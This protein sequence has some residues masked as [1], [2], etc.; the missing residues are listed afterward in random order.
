MLHYALQFVHE[1][2]THLF[3]RQ[4]SGN[5]YKY[6]EEVWRSY[7]ALRGIEDGVSQPVFPAKYGVV[8]RDEF[9]TSVAFQNVW[10]GSSGHDAPLIAY[11]ALL[12]CGGDWCE[13]IRRACLHGGDSDSTG[14]IACTWYG[15]LY[16]FRGVPK[17]HYAKLEYGARLRSLANQLYTM[18]G[19]VDDDELAV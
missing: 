1:R 3:Q 9:Y 6:F 16:G 18:H 5:G 15:A 13:L 10:G 12:G 2:H 19:P 4:A 14:V 11:D 7:L 8:E 17:N